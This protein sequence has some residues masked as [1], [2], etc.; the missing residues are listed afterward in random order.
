L[1]LSGLR[2]V[3]HVRQDMGMASS[4]RGPRINGHAVRALRIAQG[5]SQVSLSRQAGLDHSY[6]SRIER[7]QRCHP[8]PWVT[9]ALAD[10]LGVPMAA[11]LA[12]PQVVAAS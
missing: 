2:N 11:I 1:V 10:T 8:A 7:A 6:L 4:P 12:D 9:K 3:D 5:L